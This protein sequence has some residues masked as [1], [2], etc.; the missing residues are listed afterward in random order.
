MI[1]DSKIFQSDVAVEILQYVAVQTLSQELK[2]LSSVHTSHVCPAC[3]YFQ[4]WGLISFGRVNSV[5]PE[6]ELAD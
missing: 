5:A 3:R 4:D 1:S 2:A 6:S